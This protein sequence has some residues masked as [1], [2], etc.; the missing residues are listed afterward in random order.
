M[1]RCYTMCCRFGIF[2]GFHRLFVYW[3]LFLIV[4]KHSLGKYKI[5][6]CFQKIMLICYFTM[7]V[8]VMYIVMYSGTRNPET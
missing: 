3:Q 5:I 7:Y 4:Q 1:V 2:F 6:F 8:I